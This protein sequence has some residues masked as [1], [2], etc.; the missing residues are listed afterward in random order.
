M[1]ASS[2]E[3]PPRTEPP[4]AETTPFEP[5]QAEPPKTANDPL[6][7]PLAQLSPVRSMAAV[8]LGFGLFTQV[9]ARVGAVTLGL[10]LPGAFPA[11]SEDGELVVPTTVGLAAMLV[12]SLANALLAGLIA[13]RIAGLAQRWHG[14]VLGGVLGLFGAI[15]MDQVRGF[16]GWFALGYLL[17]PPVG[18]TLGGFLAE[19]VVAKAKPRIV[20]ERI[21]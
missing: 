20:S 17:L 18:A 10:L 12:M 5:P 7:H 3:S 13:G 21:H 6:A 2:E 16:P 14:V 9:L 11:Q 1:T 15:S 4:Q 19:R 8:S